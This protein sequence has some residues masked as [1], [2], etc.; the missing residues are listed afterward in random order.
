MSAADVPTFE[1]LRQML[2]DFAAQRKWAGFHTPRNLA[3]A[4][5]GEVGEICQILRWQPEHAGLPEGISSEIADVMIF[6]SYL[7][8]ACGVDICA[9]VESKILRNEDRYPA[10]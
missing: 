2:R 1:H 6:L 7:A 5:S 10:Q 4:L 3:L 9:A 8:D